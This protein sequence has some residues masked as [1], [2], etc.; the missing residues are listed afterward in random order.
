MTRLGLERIVVNDP[1]DSGPAILGTTWALTICCI[2]IVGLRFYLRCKLHAGLTASD[3]TMLGALLLQLASQGCITEA[4]Q[5]GLG[6]HDEYLL[7][8]TMLYPPDS[9]PWVQMLKW[10]Y[11]STIPGVLSSIVA[12][13]SVAML[14]ITIFG[15]KRWLKYFLI[16]F[17][18]LVAVLGSL[19]IIFSMLQSNPI[20]GL[21]NPFVPA[22]R[23]DPRVPH[24][25]VYV[26]GSVY[27]FTDLTYALF[28]VMIIWRLKLPLHRRLGLCILMAGSLFSMGACIM[29]IVISHDLTLHQSAVGMLWALLEQCLV[30]A[31][32]S[33]PILASTRRLEI[34]KSWTASIASLVDRSPLGS[35]RGSKR[36]GHS[37]GSDGAGRRRGFP[38]R[39]KA[40][41]L[42]T[43]ESPG[44][45]S[46][47]DGEKG[48]KEKMKF[49][50]TVTVY[51]TF[52]M[53]RLHRDDAHSFRSDSEN[54]LVDRHDVVPSYPPPVAGSRRIV[55]TADHDAGRMV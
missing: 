6:A 37:T 52:N 50:N 43:P 39:S 55:V 2:L 12:R 1:Q 27:A 17:T 33:A 26:G 32:G 47:S 51:S 41:Q 28:P 34:V 5:W 14:L 53:S 9:I 38:K 31:L 3:W 48:T 8:Q 49:L 24:Y 45:G 46:C 54:G 35:L 44:P 11:L 20:E 22:R 19:S 16:V 25:M 36:D 21:W 13:I 10:V 18:S 4:Y 40:I 30:I 15:T 29:R 7:P 23:W 42:R